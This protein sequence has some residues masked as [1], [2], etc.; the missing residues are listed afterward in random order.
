MTYADAVQP[1]LLAS[2]NRR[3]SLLLDKARER[4]AQ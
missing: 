2:S 4:H 3:A 1:R